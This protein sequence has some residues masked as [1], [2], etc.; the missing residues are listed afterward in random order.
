MM[1]RALVLLL[2]ICAASCMPVPCIAADNASIFRVTQVIMP[3]WDPAVG[4]DYASGVALINTYDSLVFPTPDGGVRP[5][6]AESW[7]ISDNGLT[8]DFNIRKDIVFHSGNKLTA[9]DVAYSMN[10]LL[11]I[12]EGFAFLFYQYIDSAEAVGDYTV[13]FHCKTAY[14]PLL[15]SLVRFYI[16]DQKLLESK[17]ANTGDYGENKDYGKAYLL[18][19]D[20]GSGPYT[21]DGVSTNISVSGSIYRP[22]WAGFDKDVPEK[23]IIYA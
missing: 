18:E 2:A 6:V 4:S 10:R 17:Y 16:V 21:V 19:H 8:W 13:R 1:K 11:N 20:A 9:N 3:K 23:F 7:T 12:G 14:G 15:N 22:Y 5:W